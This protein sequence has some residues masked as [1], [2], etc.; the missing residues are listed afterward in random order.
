VPLLLFL[1]LWFPIIPADP[2]ETWLEE[3]GQL[4]MPLWAPCRIH[5]V[6]RIGGQ[7]ALGGQFFASQRLQRRKRRFRPSYCMSLSFA[8]VPRFHR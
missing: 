2:R 8:K 1:F 6:G 4:T 3:A 7:G 5:V